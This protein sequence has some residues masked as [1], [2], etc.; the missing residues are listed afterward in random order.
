MVSLATTPMMCALLLGRP[1]REHRGRLHH[2]SERFFTSLQRGYDRSLSWALS[3]SLFVVLILAVTLC[4]GFARMI[5]RAAAGA[6]LKIKAHPHMLR[7]ALANKGH[8]TRAIQAGSAI[9]HEHRGLH[10][11][12][13]EPV[14]GLLAELIQ[15]S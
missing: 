7:Y 4:P 1:E 13:A 9:D 2:A 8:D 3:H 12:G 6:G 15:V 5:E 10:G 11:F 14:Q